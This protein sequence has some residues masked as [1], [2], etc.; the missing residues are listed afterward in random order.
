MSCVAV[1]CCP[2]NAPPWRTPSDRQVGPTPHSTCR[3][4]R[5]H[6]PLPRA[7]CPAPGGPGPT[8]APRASSVPEASLARIGASAT[9]T[10]AS[11]WPGAAARRAAPPPR[12][13][14]RACTRSG[15]ERPLQ[16]PRSAVALVPR[17][18]G[19]FWQPVPC[20]VVATQ[21]VVP[22]APRQEL[23]RRWQQPPQLPWRHH[24]RSRQWLQ[25]RRQKRA[26]PRLRFF[27]VVLHQLVRCSLREHVASH[28]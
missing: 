24:R 28:V 14:T 13:R 16:P 10:C 7:Q 1:C 5:V 18:A 19:H 11:C 15:A 8:Q 2:L 27:A 23:P 6:L 3:A 4:P 17:P 22:R 26:G 9:Q 21:A 25:Q 20:R 12:P